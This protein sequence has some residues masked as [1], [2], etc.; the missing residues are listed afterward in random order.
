MENV[1][2]IFIK[3][4]FDDNEVNFYYNKLLKVFQEFHYEFKSL[5]LIHTL[6]KKKKEGILNSLI[7]CNSFF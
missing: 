2:L 6:M 1:Y 3:D 7:K 4:E 5:M